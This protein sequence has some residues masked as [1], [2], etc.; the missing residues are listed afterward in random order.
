MSTAA[1]VEAAWVENI[2]QNATITAI[3]PKIY[4][5]NITDDSERETSRLIYQT[6]LNYIQYAVQRSNARAMTSQL[7]YQFLVDVVYTRKFDVAGENWTAVRDFFDTLYALVHSSLGNSWDGT[8]DY[9][10]EQEGPAEI[11]QIDFEGEP[12][13]QGKYRFIG[14]QTVSL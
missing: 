11:T 14:F 2:W 1:Q 7:E 8:V 12:A 6:E 4:G 3:T 13:W 5:F 10:R 9:W